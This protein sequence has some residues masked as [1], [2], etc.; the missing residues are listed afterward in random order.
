M[1]AAA[2]HPALPEGEDTVVRAR[3][4]PLDRHQVPFLLSDS[5]LHRSS[6]WGKLLSTDA[7]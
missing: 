3:Q 6:L 4:L 5:A 2:M 1:F 7:L